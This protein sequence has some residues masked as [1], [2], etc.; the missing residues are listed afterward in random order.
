[1]NIYILNI[2]SHVILC[3]YVNNFQLFIHISVVE[4]IKRLDDV[5]DEVRNVSVRVIHQLFTMLPEEYDLNTNKSHL[6]YIF[7]SMIIH[8][9]DENSEFQKA[10][11]SKIHFIK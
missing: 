6:E 2:I 7:G 9:G 11:F 1:M 8:L 5:S 3:T 4:L 10:L